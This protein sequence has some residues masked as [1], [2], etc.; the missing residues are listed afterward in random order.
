VNREAK[1][2]RRYHIKHKKI[3]ERLKNTS[4]QADEQ[5]STKRMKCPAD[6]LRK[7]INIKVSLN[8]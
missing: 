4:N 1:I 2:T 8:P 7:K 6:I 3:R 5:Q